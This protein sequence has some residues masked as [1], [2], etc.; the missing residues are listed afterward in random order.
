[1]SHNCDPVPI[2]NLR[3]V[4]NYE[5]DV[6]LQ[7][8]NATGIHEPCVWNQVPSYHCVVNSYCDVA[9]DIYEGMLRYDMPAVLWKLIGVKKYFT[10]ETFC[11]RVEG[12]DY[13]PAEQGNRPP[14][15]QFTLELLENSSINLSASEMLCLARYLGEMIG[16]LVPED[17]VIWKFYLLVRE[18]VD[19]VTSPV[20]E[21]GVD[22]YLDILV[23]EH[24]E[25][26]L[27][28]F[29]ALKPKQ[30]FMV[31][32]GRLL[33]RNGS[34]SLISA[35]L[36]ERN[37]RKGKAYARVCNSRINPAFS[38]AIKHQLYLCERLM[39]PENERPLKVTKL[40]AM[41]Y[42]T[43]KNY[44]SFANL[45][46]LD[47]DAIVS[48]AESVEIHGTRYQNNMVLVVQVGSLLPTFGKIVHCVILEDSVLFVINVLKTV[49]YRGHICSYEVQTSCEWVCVKHSELLYYMPLWQ[50]TYFDGKQTVSIKHIL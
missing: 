43:L 49:C 35:L 14:T 6:A 10:L 9:H 47:P 44:E 41:Q 42:R 17:C 4:Q 21:P 2:H 30:H 12:F 16:D 48:V 15:S 29:G 34:L 40:H 36:C 26:Y 23:K 28:Y 20:F 8:A 32:Y 3:N 33:R 31:H 11:E 38:V 39:R 13:G 18:I 5:V 50:R 45:Y 24:N 7:D 37:H 46:P 25:M 19:I 1:M 27:L 22:L